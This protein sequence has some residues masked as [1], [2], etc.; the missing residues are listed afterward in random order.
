MKESV[1]DKLA[2]DVVTR[3]SCNGMYTEEFK[4]HLEDESTSIIGEV[5]E[6]L[7]K[8]GTHYQREILD[9]V[10]NVDRIQHYYFDNNKYKGIEET[11]LGL[12]LFKNELYELGVID[13]G[14]IENRTE[15][16]EE[17][18]LIVQDKLERLKTELSQLLFDTKQEVKPRTRPRPA[19]PA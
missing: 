19:W 13:Y 15:P 9:I 3:T 17:F 8:L 14:I 12:D 11:I 5:K 16:K 2:L 4:Q 6:L 1:D 7:S 10:I 18:Y